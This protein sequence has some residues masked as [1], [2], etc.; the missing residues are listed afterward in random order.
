MPQGV[1]VMEVPNEDLAKLEG[2]APAYCTT[3]I[4]RVRWAIETAAA[5]VGAQ[6]AVESVTGIANPIET[7]EPP[8]NAPASP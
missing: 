7:P 6:R 5:A 4:S 1:T 8:Q 3:A 2:K